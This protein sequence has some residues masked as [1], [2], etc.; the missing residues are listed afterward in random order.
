LLLLASNQD[1]ASIFTFIVLVTTVGN[2]VMYL[3]AA[4]A[5]FLALR[6]IP[7]RVVIVLGGAFTLFAFY[8]AGF[9]ANAWGLLLVVAGLVVRSATRVGA[10]KRAMVQAA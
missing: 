9:E 6:S 4:I 10:A 1:A 3:L 8:G 2:L 7:G 5:S